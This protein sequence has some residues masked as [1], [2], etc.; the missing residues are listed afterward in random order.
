MS[1]SC[2]VLYSTEL[3]LSGENRCQNNLISR[4][5]EQND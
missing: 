2:V 3:K 5:K 1:L 4:Q